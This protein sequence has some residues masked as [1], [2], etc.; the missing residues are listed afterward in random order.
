MTGK[1]KSITNPRLNVNILSQEDVESIHR[2]TL[3]IIESVGVKFPS[4]KA[5][6]IWASHGAKVD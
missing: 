1:I 4:L 3:E 2:A 6:D 5:L